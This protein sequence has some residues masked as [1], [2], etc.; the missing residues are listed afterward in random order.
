[1]IAKYDGKCKV[2]GQVI[3][4]GET[5]LVKL[6]GIWQVK[7]EVV[8]SPTG[9]KCPPSKDRHTFTHRGYTVF[10]YLYVGAYGH[11]K[12]YK[13]TDEKG[14]EL[15][16]CNK[17]LMVMNTGSGFRNPVGDSKASTERVMKGRLDWMDDVNGERSAYEK[18]AEE[19]GIA[20]W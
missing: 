12:V 1:M 17:H 4:A 11:W 18:K 3:K 16:L 10:S 19:E 7:P 5:E 15:D 8:T 14:Q 13:I 6:N 9:A 2:T 20:F